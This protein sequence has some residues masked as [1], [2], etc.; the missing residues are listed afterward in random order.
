MVERFQCPFVSAC[1]WIIHWG[2]FTIVLSDHF[3]GK[4][5]EVE[6]ARE[7][8]EYLS[9][10]ISDL[11]KYID[12]R[13]QPAIQAR[14]DTWICPSCKTLNPGE[15]KICRQCKRLRPY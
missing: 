7:R 15:L 4:R 12:L 6:I 2:L 8:Y 9:E 3:Q 14:A 1:G 10:R 13:K 5:N 11:E